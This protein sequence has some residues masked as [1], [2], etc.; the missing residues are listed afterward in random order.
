VPLP[1]VEVL[2]KAEATGGFGATH[3]LRTCTGWTPVSFGCRLEGPLGGPERHSL[4]NWE[5]S[6]GRSFS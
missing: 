4:R 6:R 5:R 2:K 3:W 1:I